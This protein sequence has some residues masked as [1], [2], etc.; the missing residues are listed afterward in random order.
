MA[1]AYA[2][3]FH[4]GE[5]RTPVPMDTGMEAYSPGKR[6]NDHTK[7]VNDQDTLMSDHNKA[8]ITHLQQDKHQNTEPEKKKR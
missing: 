2:P 7:L 4:R 8:P 3:D 6:K 1:A 5:D